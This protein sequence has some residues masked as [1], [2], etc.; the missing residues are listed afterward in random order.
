MPDFQQ[1][2]RSPFALTGKTLGIFWA[3]AKKYP[4]HL[5]GV[6]SGVL[7]YAGIGTYLTLLYRD[8]IDAI[9]GAVSGDA[10]V[11]AIQV[12]GWILIANIA[13]S[14][15]WRFSN[16][17]NNYFQ[18]T[19][20][21]DLTNTCYEY[22]QNHSIGFFNS[23][24]VGSLVTKVKRYERAFEQIADQICFDLGR[25]LLETGMILTVIFWQYPKFGMYLLVWCVLFLIFSYAY[26]IFKLPYDIKRAAADTRTTGQ[27]ADS[28]TNNVNVKLFTNYSHEVERFNEVTNEQFSLRKKSWDLGTWGD[29]FQGL[30]MVGLEFLVVYVAVGQWAQGILTVGG[31]VLLQRYFFRVFEQLWNTGK[32]IRTIY[33][34]LAD[35]NEMTEMLLRP[36][37]IQD[38]PSAK[39][40]KVKKGEIEFRDVS[41]GYYRESAVLDHFN[42]TV[43]AGER[44]AFI[45]S[46]GGGKSTIAKLLFRFHDVTGGEVLID[47]QNIAGVTQDS[48]RSALSFVP[49]D[50]IL[51]HRSLME[52][53][54]Y[55]LPSATDAQVV[56]AAKLAHAHEF[57]SSFRQG[58][59][60]LVGERGLKLSG[61]ERQRVAIARAILR[62]APILVLDEATS[63]LDSESEQYIQEAMKKMMERCTTI[64]IAHRLSTIMQMD[65][66]VVIGDGKIIEEGKHKELVKMKQGM[67]QK[68][69]QI[70]AGGFVG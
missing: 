19:V 55:A 5:A 44:V 51:F 34:A 60:T 35:A 59:D 36:H 45:G 42:L 15:Y 61:G 39:I 52:N 50:P 32:N 48:L 9:S 70:Q 8:L 63:S 14:L 43:K 62:N 47:G 22:L 31:V 6:I 68:L 53:I 3:H 40:L 64:V 54:R 21:R 58:Y 38:A 41:F 23:S 33:E 1:S 26:S 2:N 11:R 69:W 4:W 20:M 67:Y 49:Q 10:Y 25:S 16:F 12:I 24:F 13:R 37:E 65:R 18:P 28:I 29:V 27:L 7:V 17:V 66:I 30:S 57:I 46:S 56:K